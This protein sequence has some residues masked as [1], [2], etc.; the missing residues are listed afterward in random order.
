[1]MLGNKIKDGL[2]IKSSV[3]RIAYQIYENNIDEKSIVIVGIGNPG[4]IFRNLIGNSIKSICD[5]N[6]IF[7]SLTIKK[8]KLLNVV[9]SDISL[10][11][12]KNKSIIIVDDVLNTGST[13]IYAVS[14]FLKIP[15]KKIQTAVMVNRNHKKFPI[16]AD[17]KGISLS[18]SVNEHI[19]VILEGNEI[20]IYL[21]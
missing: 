12:I 17:F 21:S 5:L 18:T 14:Y 6:L 2:A 10:E 11:E 15:V 19:S 3:K 1:M 4:K 16:K 7:V 13:L 8:K 20:G 9:E